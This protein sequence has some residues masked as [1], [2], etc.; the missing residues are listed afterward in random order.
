MGPRTAEDDPKDRDFVPPKNPRPRSESPVEDI[1]LDKHGNEIVE[2]LPL[3]P[4]RGFLDLLSIAN[5][6]QGKAET[7]SCELW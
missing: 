7:H 5:N 2:D 6:Q 4:V 3:V 1:A